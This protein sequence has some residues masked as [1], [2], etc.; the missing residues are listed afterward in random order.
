MVWT[1]EINKMYL[2][3]VSKP[4]KEYLKPIKR[5]SIIHSCSLPW[6]CGVVQKARVRP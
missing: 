1:K 6:I 3:S 4:L 5:A 2:Q